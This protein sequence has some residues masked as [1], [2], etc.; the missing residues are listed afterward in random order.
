MD[1]VLPSMG[2][3]AFSCLFDINM[4]PIAGMERTD[5]QWRKPLEGVGLRVV[6]IQMPL[7]GDGII[8][9]VLADEE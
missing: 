1:V 8:E 3:S 9:A 5:G 2:A 7:I 6:D 4:I